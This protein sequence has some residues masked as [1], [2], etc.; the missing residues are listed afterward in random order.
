MVE[1]C[2]HNKPL[3]S[4]FMFVMMHTVSNRWWFITVALL[5]MFLNW[6]ACVAFQ[7]KRAIG[8]YGKVFPK[9]R[10]L[11][12]LHYNMYDYGLDAFISFIPCSYM[13]TVAKTVTHIFNWIIHKVRRNKPDCCTTCSHP[14]GSKVSY[15]WTVLCDYLRQMN[16][17]K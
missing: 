8:F 16:S 9:H 13:A 4:S 2:S 10:I 3:V 17:S 14:I 6:F 15:I 7:L 11:Q 1:L 12:L 5:H